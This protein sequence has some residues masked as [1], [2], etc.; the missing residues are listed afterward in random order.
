MPDEPERLELRAAPP[1]WS[2]RSLYLVVVA[3]LAAEIA[4]FTAITLIC[5]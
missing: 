1:F 4:V 2:W 5:R 3:A